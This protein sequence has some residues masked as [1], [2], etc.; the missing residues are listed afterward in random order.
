MKTK[1]FC[2][3][4]NQMPTQSYNI[5]ADMPTKPLP[6]LH[7][8]TKQPVTKEQMSAIFAE[9]LDRRRSMSTE[10]SHRPPEEVAGDLPELHPHRSCARRGWKRPSERRRRSIF[11]N[12]SVFARG[13]PHKPDA[14]VPQSL[15]RLPAGHRPGH[16]RDRRRRV[17]RFDRLRGR[18]LRHRPAGA[19]GQGQLRRETATADLTMEHLGAA[20]AWCVAL[21]ADQFGARS[22][23]TRPSTCSGSL[24][25]AI[26]EAVEMALRRP[27]DTR[28]LP[29][30]RPE[31][32]GA[33]PDGY[34]TGGREADGDGRCRARHGDRMLRR[35]Q[36][37]RRRFGFPFLQKNLT[38]G[39]KI[40]VIAVEPEGCPKPAHGASYEDD[41]GDAAGFT[42]PA[43]A[44]RA[45]GM[46]FQPSD[47]HAGGLALPRSGLDRRA[48]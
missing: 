19:H 11:K 35:R 6:P 4:E 30:Q 34:R 26:S 2:L 13:V 24:G 15:L 10:R 36:R 32:R 3:S 43:A 7:P 25:L 48:S 40:R 45:W 42:H 37:L 20:G 22:A 12:E 39:K 41:S 47:I 16:D 14:A 5:V 1:K 38:E 27:E 23:G 29:G 28:Y 17:G 33:A 31:P 9:E 44:V 18:T 8:A 46:Y 21:D